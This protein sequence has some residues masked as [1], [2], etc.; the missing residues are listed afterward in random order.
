M[1][2]ESRG[3]YC[4]NFQTWSSKLTDGKVC[5]KPR[6]LVYDSLSTT[7]NRSVSLIFVDIFFWIANFLILDLL[8]FF[9]FVHITIPYGLRKIFYSLLRHTKFYIL[10]EDVSKIPLSFSDKTMKTCIK[11]MQ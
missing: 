6:E 8:I 7:T 4:D 1:S 10:F 9:T 11:C 5:F 2:R 3:G